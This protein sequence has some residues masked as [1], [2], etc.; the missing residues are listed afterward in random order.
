MGKFLQLESDV[1]S[2]FGS[3]AWKA[4][5]IQTYP[6]NFIPKT[7]GTEFIRVSI[8][9]SG[10]GVNLKSVTGMIIVDI[11]TL[12]GKGPRAATIIADKLDEYLVGKSLETVSGQCVQ[13]MHSSFTHKEVDKDDPTLYSSSY[14]IIFKYFGV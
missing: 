14:T 2:I 8:L 13:L 5:Q 7:F 4:E 6:S 9:A 1:F 3:D 10:N 12:A 11:F